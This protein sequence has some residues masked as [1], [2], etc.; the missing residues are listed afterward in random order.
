MSPCTQYTRILIKYKVLNDRASNKIIFCLFLVSSSHLISTALSACN[1]VWLS[2]GCLRLYIM[3]CTRFFLYSAFSSTLNKKTRK[4]K[5]FLIVFSYAWMPRDFS[6]VQCESMDYGQWQTTNY[7][8][9]W[10]L[11]FR[12]SK[13]SIYDDD[14]AHHYRGRGK[15]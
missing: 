5:T 11:K 6:F 3:S 1:F 12:H 7:I 2:L 9:L 4:K 13:L 14:E 10:N 8:I 15:N